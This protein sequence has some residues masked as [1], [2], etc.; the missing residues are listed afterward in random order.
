MN[1]SAIVSLPARLL[2]IMPFML[3]SGVVGGIFVGALVY[4]DRTGQ[5]RDRNE[6]G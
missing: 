1:P 2:S 4:R 6:R 3:L 5:A